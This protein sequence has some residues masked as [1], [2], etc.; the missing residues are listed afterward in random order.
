[1]VVGKIVGDA[2]ETSQPSGKDIY[3]SWRTPVLFQDRRVFQR[4]DLFEPN[5]LDDAELSNV[6]RM[7]VGRPPIGFDDEPVNLH[8]LIQQ[9]PGTIAEV[10]GRAHSKNTKT[11]HI[12]QFE[13]FNGILRPRKNYSFRAHDGRRASWPVT[14]SGKIRKTK[15]EKQF[16]KWSSDY[17]K[18]RAEGYES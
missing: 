8:H 12:P 17:W 4:D 1:M 7:R 9:E 14:K 13:K 16:A 11:L 2:S 18:H 3:S 5:R 15:Q 6:E 10:G